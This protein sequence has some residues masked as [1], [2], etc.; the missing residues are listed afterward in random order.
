MA[1]KAD[2]QSEGRVILIDKPL[3]WTSFDVVKKVRKSSPE[4]KVGHAGTLDPLAT[5]LLILCTGKLT[6]RIAEFQEQEKEYT[7]IMEI[8]KTT[9]SVDLEKPFDSQTPCDH[10]TASDV[11]SIVSQFIGE[12]YQ[13]PPVFSAVKV[14]GERLYEK[15]RKGENPEIKP[16][17]IK[18]SEFE[19]TKINL[20]EIHFRLVCSKGTYVRSLARDFGAKLGVGAYLKELRRTRIGNFH[21]SQAMSISDKL[22]D[23]VRNEEKT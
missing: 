16:K 10:I 9:P 7:G 6:K 11:L 8:G 21:V 20:P 18:I 2:S 19:L 5:G 12:I 1:G 4:K 3:G 15:A 17:K 23:L 13:V 22:P 14:K